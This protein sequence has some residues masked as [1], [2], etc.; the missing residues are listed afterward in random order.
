MIGVFNARYHAPDTPP[1][2]GDAANV[3]KASL[4]DVAAPQPEVQQAETIAGHVSPSDIHDWRGLDEFAVYRHSTGECRKMQASE[5]WKIE[6]PAL[7]GD[8]FT[9]ARIME[10]FAPIG[11]ADMYNSGGAILEYDAMEK[12]AT[13]RRLAMRLRGEGRFLAWCETRPAQVHEGN[14]ILPF[15]YAED[16]HLLEFQLPYTDSRPVTIEWEIV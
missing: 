3:E 6:M 8:I 13:Q 16:T 11:L 9:V 12:T 1:V 4:S 2:P 7:T 14:L 15:T 10:G 5:R